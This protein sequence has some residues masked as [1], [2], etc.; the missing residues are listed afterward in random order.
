[1]T[2]VKSHFC[3]ICGNEITSTSRKYCGASCR[4]QAARDFNAVA[5]AEDQARVAAKKDTTTF[6]K[7]DTAKLRYTL[8]PPRA[9]EG[10][11]AVLE[12]G[13]RKYAPGNWAK[14]T[15]ADALERY[16]NAIH[17]HMAAIAR[18]EMVDPESGHFH[19]AHVA[20]SALFILGFAYGDADALKK[21]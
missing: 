16:S 19:A 4:L 14:T 20:C 8:L 7:D 2:S 11:V 15:Q 12:Y 13:A 6:V 1:M 17:R 5:L 9:L 3:L 21:T 18:G 10:V